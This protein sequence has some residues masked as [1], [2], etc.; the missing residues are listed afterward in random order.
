MSID[1]YFQ[2]CHLGY[3]SVLYSICVE[4]FEWEVY[5]FGL[6]SFFFNQ[7]FVNS[8]MCASGVYQCLDLEVLA[9]L[10]FHVCSHIQFSFHITLSIWNNIF[11]LRI[12]RRDL[13]Y[14]AYLRSS[15]KP[16]FSL[17][18]FSSSDS[19][20]ISCFFIDCFPL[21]FL[22]MCH[23]LSYLKYFLV[24]FSFFFQYSLAMCPYLL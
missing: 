7:L 16:Y 17:L 23:F 4:N 1:F 19:S 15:P 6:Y 12:Y 13:S 21:Q 8:H 18:S 9:I 2:R 24:S 22:A 14:H 11:I 20:W 3:F 10:H 5:W